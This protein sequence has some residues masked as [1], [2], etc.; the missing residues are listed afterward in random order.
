M[1][2]LR[3]IAVCFAVGSVLALA[4]HE[5]AEPMGSLGSSGTTMDAALP[6]ADA[7][8]ADSTGGL[9]DPSCIDDYQGNQAHDAALE[10]ALDTRADAL[11]ALGD[12]FVA[13][14]PELGNDALV[15]C[16]TAPADF[17]AFEAQCP[18]YLSIEA[19][20][21][22]GGIPEL[23]LHDDSLPQGAAPLEQAWGDWYGFFLKPIQ[24]RLDEGAYAI[25]VRHA[26]GG[27]QRYGLTVA[28]LPETPCPP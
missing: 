12:G 10:L 17:F 22:E 7:P 13:D 20:T 24:R 8:V 4:C 18:G 15:V 16:S 9:L 3:T 5:D 25:E 11:V 19:R 1:T 6:P 28:W 2:A 27:P 23:L 14:P 21:L 26:G